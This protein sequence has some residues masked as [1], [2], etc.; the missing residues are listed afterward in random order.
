M[1]WE[2]AKQEQNEV[3]NANKYLEFKQPSARLNVSLITFLW[4]IF[5]FIIFL[6]S[7]AHGCGLYCWCACCVCYGNLRVRCSWIHV[8]HFRGVFAVFDVNE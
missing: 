7:S 6:W 3:R 1:H 2:K 8:N 5:I 4:N